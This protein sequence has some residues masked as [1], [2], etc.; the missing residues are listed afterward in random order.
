MMR[1]R[2]LLLVLVGTLAVAAGPAPAGAGPWTS[3]T[4]PYDYQAVL[5]QGDTVWCATLESG[6][7]QFHPMN[8]P[9]DSFFTYHREPG[10]LASNRLTSLAIERSRRLWVGTDGAGVSRLSADR[11]RWDLIKTFDGLP[12]DSITVLVS[13]GDS[14]WIGTTKGI[15]LWNGGAIAGAIPNGVDPSP[16]ANDHITG[17]VPR[18]DS[19]WV[20]TLDGIYVSRIS[21][22][23]QSWSED[24]AGLLTTSVQALVQSGTSLV[25]LSNRA[26]F[27][28]DDAQARWSYSPNEASATSIG[29]VLRLTGQRG[30]AIASTDRGLWRWGTTNWLFVSDGFASDPSDSRRQYRTGIGEDGRVWAANNAGLLEQGSTPYNWPNH[31]PISPPGND[32]IN[33]YPF[34]PRLY[35]NTYQ[36]GFGR[37]D[38]SLWRDWPPSVCSG[39]CDS[40][41]GSSYFL[42]A[43]LVDR[44]G[45]VWT[46][47]W[48]TDIEEID[49]TVS[50][51][52]FIHHEIADPVTAGPERHTFGWPAIEDA[53]GGHWIGLAHNGIVEPI[54]ALGIDYYDAAGN[55]VRN[56]RPDSVPSMRGY[57]V[58]SMHRAIRTDGNDR[59]FVGYSERGPRGLQYFDRPIADTLQMFHLVPGTDNLEVIG[60]AN[61]GDSLWVLTTQDLRRYSLTS[62]N[63]Q[64]AFSRP[65]SSAENALHPLDVGPDGTVWLGS[66]NGLRALHPGNQVDDYSTSNSPLVDNRVRAIRVDPVTGVVWIGTG[67]GVNRFDPYYVAPGDVIP[68]SLTI[69]A[70]PNPVMLTAIGV[71]IRL[72]GNGSHYT[73]DVF[74]VRGRRMRH[75]AGVVNDQ[76]FWDARDDEGNLV[77]PGVYFIHAETGGRTATARVALIR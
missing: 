27:V 5:L 40:T 18:G 15:A 50:P 23:F 13:Q 39:P 68:P 51:P 26:P 77:R 1:M 47:S 11:A 35:V 62:L 70:Y 33:L 55:Y 65:G 75:I 56:F 22:G 52:V 24:T 48:S 73:V 12:E 25:A 45:H 21:T 60:I 72:R 4:H 3:F 58:R 31:V 16:F 66:E 20:S 44:R 17:I 7:L 61:H 57:E 37:F 19:L 10:G 36:E 59:I 30:V 38:G 46:A 49:D 29:L 69:Q 2:R 76:T 64:G 41:F 63:L 32:V 67:G 42:Y 74:D 6:L 43:L 9:P 71:P 8:G 54:V 14:I 53:D 28:Y 34:G